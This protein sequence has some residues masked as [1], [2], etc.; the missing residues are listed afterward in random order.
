MTRVS[1]DEWRDGHV[2]N[3]FDYAL[4]VWVVEGV[5]QP[6]GHPPAMSRHAP[7]CAAASLGRPTN[8]SDPG[9]AAAKRRMTR[10]SHSAR[11]RQ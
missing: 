11:G 1:G 7:C 8:R 5:V 10:A 4:Q 6:C 9:R 3:G 2:W